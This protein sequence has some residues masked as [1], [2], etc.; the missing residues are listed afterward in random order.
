VSDI[1]TAAVDSLKALDLK[2]PIREADIGGMSHYS[3]LFGPGTDCPVLRGFPTNSN[4]RRGKPTS[5]SAAT[6]L[7]PAGRGHAGGRTSRVGRKHGAFERR[8]PGGLTQS[9]AHNR[10]I[11]PRSPC[12]ALG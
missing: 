6:D 12:D 2:R 7:P 5:A 4:W 10:H 8:T 3:H 1:D 11:F 9:R